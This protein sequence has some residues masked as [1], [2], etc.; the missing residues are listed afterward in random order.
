MLTIQIRVLALFVLVHSY[1][2]YH[3]QAFQQR[4]EFEVNGSD[5]RKH[6]NWH[7]LI[8]S[9]AIVSSRYFLHSAT[10]VDAHIT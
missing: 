4:E 6:H 9:G 5:S 10:V 1:D 7:E 3:A 8:I 2:S